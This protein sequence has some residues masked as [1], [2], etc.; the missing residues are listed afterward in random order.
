MIHFSLRCLPDGHGFDGWFRSNGDF[1]R[2]AGAGLV[3]CP[4]C[5]A[6]AV[7]KALMHPAIA[8]GGPAR[9]NAEPEASGA[10]APEP[11]GASGSPP[12]APAGAAAA[13]EGAV[14]PVP[15]QTLANLPAPHPEVARAFAVLQEISRKVRA[16]ADYVGG[17][18]AEEARRIH[19]GESEARQIYGE[20]SP[21]DVEGL[22]EEGITALPLLPLPEDKQ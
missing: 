21:K 16:E 15:A 10:A 18:F 11:A 17:R 13:G 5:G 6:T 1:D 20:A 4:V 3:E 14:A 7:E 12:A 8:R 22:K 19:Y 9:M 2:Q